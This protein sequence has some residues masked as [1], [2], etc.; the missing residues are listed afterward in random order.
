MDSLKTNKSLYIDTEALSTLALVQAG[1]ISPV[2][3]LM[4]KE[5]A[6]KVDNEQQ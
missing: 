1:L 3:K 2:E 6:K 4:N 5:E